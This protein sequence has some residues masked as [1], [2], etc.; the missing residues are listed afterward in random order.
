MSKY[1]EFVNKTL[2]P[3]ISPLAYLFAAKSIIT[4]SAFSLYAEYSDGVQNTILYKE[5]ALIGTGTWGALVLIG[6]II[7]L[8][9]IISKA[10][11]GVLISSM[12]LF[13]AWVFASIV[14]VSSGY[15][16]Y[17]LPLA[18]VEF[19]VWGYFYLTAS[20]GILWKEVPPEG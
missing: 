17:L 4:G 18:M 11:H 20:A 2:N 3:S 5:G 14:Y 19:L 1:T 6:G 15:A 10:R 13:T 8:G 12:L 9:S 7:F 16:Q